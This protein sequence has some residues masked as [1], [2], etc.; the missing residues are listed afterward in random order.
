MKF[1]K[2][3]FLFSFAFFHISFAA[4]YTFPTKTVTF[5]TKDA[6]VIVGSYYYH[7]DNISRPAVVCLHMWQGSRQDWDELAKKLQQQGF[8]VLSIDLRGH[9]ESIIKREKNGKEK[10][11]HWKK[12]KY[13]VYSE[14]V[15]DALAA[16]N[17]LLQQDNVDVQRIGL[18][19]GS[20]GCSVAIKLAT[21]SEHIRSIALLSPAMNY[22]GVDLSRDLP[23]LSKKDI[24]IL[25]FLE[26]TDFNYTSGKKFFTAYPGKKRLK[27]YNEKGH[28]TRL[29]LSDVK[30]EIENEII[31]QLNDNLHNKNP[32]FPPSITAYTDNDP[33]EFVEK[34]CSDPALLK[35]LVACENAINILAGLGSNLAKR[36]LKK[37]PDTAVTNPYN[38]LFDL[39]R[40][41]DSYTASAVLGDEEFVSDFE[42]LNEHLLKFFNKPFLRYKINDGKLYDLYFL[43]QSPEKLK[44]LL[45]AL[46]HVD[47]AVWPVKAVETALKT[48]LA[49][50]ENNT[51]SPYTYDV[52]KQR[53]RQRYKS[54]FFTELSSIDKKQ[55]SDNL[56]NYLLSN[57][58]VRLGKIDDKLLLT[59]TVKFYTL[60][61]TYF[62]RNWADLKEFIKYLPQLT[63]QAKQE[64]RPLKIKVFA[65][66]TGQEAI[67]FAIELLEHGIRDFYILATD[68]NPQVI[69]IA[70]EMDFQEDYFLRL[71]E[72]IQQR[73]LKYFVKSDRGYRIKDL[74]F[75]KQHI[76]FK[77]Q[78]ILDDLPNNLP[79]QFA[80]PY[81]LVS[82]QNVL[83][84]IDR[85]EVDKNIDKVFKVL[86]TGGL[87][88]L[89]DTQYDIGSFYNHNIYARF[90]RINHLLSQKFYET[91]NSEALIKLYTERLKQ[92][93]TIDLYFYLAFTC[94]H[95]GN[96]EKAIATLHEAEK[97]YPFSSEI[98][99]Q[100]AVLHLHADD[101]KSARKYLETALD[102]NPLSVDYYKTYVQ[103]LRNKKEKLYYH[104]IIEALNK[105]LQKGLGKIETNAEAIEITKAARELLPRQYPAYLF[106][107]ILSSHKANLYSKKGDLAQAKTSIN[108]AIV[109]LQ[110]ALNQNP[111]FYYIYNELGKTYLNYAKLLCADNNY[112]QAKQYFDLAKQ[113]ADKSLA[114]KTS[115]HG[116]NLLAGLYYERGIVDIELGQIENAV[117]NLDTAIDDYKKIRL[118]TSDRYQLYLNTSLCYYKKALAHKELAD[119]NNAR[120]SL[121]EARK[122]L[123]S[124]LELN[125]IYGTEAYITLGQCE[126][127]WQKMKK[128][129]F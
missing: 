45:Y 26:E 123:N 32:I 97:L 12:F 19:G 66:S 81:D 102:I 72:Q 92:N 71:P 117:H 94:L 76:D 21:V 46:G 28:G 75:F 54:V 104:K 122:W 73:L 65:C 50:L 120:I 31:T 95:S 103:L 85:E 59:L 29:F 112:H 30:S 35:E 79:K 90:F 74:V 13:A 88:I 124:A 64:D 5:T 1:L 125:S 63:S 40:P 57:G 16:E 89:T 87:L 60:S 22:L 91:D 110:K 109:Y 27:V 4:A 20:L 18:I 7:N 3:F 99:A 84:Y 115:V 86:N 37:S 127:L 42:L 8:I 34:L 121:E 119:Y 53:I 48:Y 78:N 93:P 69:D 98:S 11:I 96:L 114:L 2:L 126:E 62:Y 67:T 70:R 10:N 33:I 14:M 108:Q 6:V 25:V 77:V 105:H 80:P 51:L 15:N 116:Y 118:D 61:S 101:K 58:I 111:N 44:T 55:L 23:K 47:S 113:N 82:V 24:P 41:I 100:L 43:I 68:Y 36:Q 17:F 128:A 49:A 39:T 106:L 56:N 107:G 83:M 38:L 129:A 52:L 9:G